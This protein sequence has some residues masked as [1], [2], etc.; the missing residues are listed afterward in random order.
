ME[1][2]NKYYTPSIEEFYVGFEYEDGYRVFNNYPNSY[3]DRF[4]IKIL[5]TTTDLID[6]D[7]RINNRIGRLD[8]SIRVKY[9]SKED[10]ESLGWSKWIGEADPFYIGDDEGRAYYLWITPKRISINFGLKGD[11]LKDSIQIF[12]GCVKNKSELQKLMKQLGI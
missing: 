4:T 7:D 6:I 8:N 3:V 10:I 2:D 9:L 1:I 5:K 11:L 12:R